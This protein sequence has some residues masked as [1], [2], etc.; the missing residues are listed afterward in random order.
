MAFFKEAFDDLDLDGSGE[1]GVL[2][3]GR[4]LRVMGTRATPEELKD[5]VTDIGGGGGGGVH[6]RIL[7][8]PCS[9]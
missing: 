6:G 5:M 1:I 3:F 8:V 2:E 9:Y 7:V 4:T